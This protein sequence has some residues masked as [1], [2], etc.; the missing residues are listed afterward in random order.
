[1]LPLPSCFTSATAAVPALVTAHAR[2]VRRA[3]VPVASESATTSPSNGKDVD[4]EMSKDPTSVTASWS[5]MS[6][7]NTSWKEIP[8]REL[9]EE[10]LEELSRSNASSDDNVANAAVKE[11]HI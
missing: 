3:S 7:R 2:N 11:S 5:S 6:S 10:T 8:V 9:P 1:M 4:S